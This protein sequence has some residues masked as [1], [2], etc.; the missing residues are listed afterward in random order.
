M[1]GTAPSFYGYDGHGSVRQLFNSSG[2]MT[3]TYDYDAFGN[4]INSTGSTP[5]VYLFAGEAY[6]AALGL[7]YNRARYLNTTMDRFWSMD[8]Y[9]GDSESPLSLHKY[10]YV[11]ASP[12]NRIDPTGHEDLGSLMGAFAV[13][14]VI[15]ALS[16][17]AFTPV[18]SPA[19]VEVH[20]DEIKAFPRAHHA[21]IL[22]SGQGEPTLIFRGG[23]S[24]GEG[25]GLSD[26]VYGEVGSDTSADCGYLVSN[27]SDQQ[28]GPNSR[29][30][31]HSPG[32]DVAQ[33]AI[34]PLRPSKYDELRSAFSSAAT[35]IDALHLPYD[36]VV[37]N[38]NAFAY[39]LLRWASL[40]ATEPPVWTP[41]WGNQLLSVP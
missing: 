31:P 14:A 27:G 37:Q 9:E 16:T 41:G 30:Y 8:S 38:S 17:I 5:N 36:P 24:G 29:D 13:A 28:F 23:P 4:L 33:M 25:C 7:Y 19:R 11:S 2:V 15:V 35:R 6:D 26:V 32:D 18:T 40:L 3:D 20:F 34:P 22:L 10:L 12:V 39:T 1:S 21:Y